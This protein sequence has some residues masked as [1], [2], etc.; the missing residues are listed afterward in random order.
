M[1][2]RKRC[3]TVPATRISR[4]A[5]GAGRLVA[6]RSKAIAGDGGRDQWEEAFRTSYSM[7]TRLVRSWKGEPHEVT[8]VE[9]GFD[10]RGQRFATFWR[11]PALRNRI[12]LGQITHKGVP[13]PGL[14]R[15]MACRKKRRISGLL[16]EVTV[17]ISVCSNRL[18]VFAVAVFC[19]QFA[20]A[21]GSSSQCVIH[22]GEQYSA[23][24]FQAAS[25]CPALLRTGGVACDGLPYRLPVGCV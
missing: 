2:K 10:Y 18:N 20:F 17:G 6:V 14:M 7:S 9:D 21:V 22:R 16:E 4:V 25:L 12:Y 13:F 11:S 3:A 8:V 19:A 24:S 5:A 15:R 23:L 1:R